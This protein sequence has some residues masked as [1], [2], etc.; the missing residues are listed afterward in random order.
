MTTITAFEPD[1]ADLEAIVSEVCTSF[2]GEEPAIGDEHAAGDDA[3]HGTVS[4]T[5]AWQGH[6][7]VAA[8]AG[9][10]REIAAEFLAMDAAEVDEA[11][12][13]DALG[14]LANMVGG[15]VKSLAPGPSALSLPLVVRGGRSSAPDTH[16]VCRT[17]ASWR[18]GSI[19]VT[20]LA[21]TR[22]NTSPI[23]E[24]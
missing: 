21:A 2:L 3:L 20:V 7:I 5:G 19:A 15:S 24:E 4:I 10:A 22:R 1:V 14:E 6:V 8:S 13:T 23:N 17:V 16:P 12:V 18:A 9:T 11:D